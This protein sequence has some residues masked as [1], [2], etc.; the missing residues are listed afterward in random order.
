MKNHP[1]IGFKLQNIKTEQFA[2]LEENYKQEKPIDLTTSI[3]FKIN[4]EKMQIGVF[5]K[6]E[7]SQTKSIFLKIELSCHFELKK[8]SWDKLKKEENTKLEVPKDFLAHLLIITVGTTRGVLFAKTENT[9]YH[10]FIIPSLDINEM[11]DK[12]AVFD[13]GDYIT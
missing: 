11:V 4:P 6:F 9:P 5:A 7:F 10:Q 12:D 1:K 3:A 13:L 2:I 8:Q